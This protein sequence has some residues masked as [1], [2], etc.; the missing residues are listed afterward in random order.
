MHE[1]FLSRLHSGPRVYVPCLPPA[2][3]ADQG[4]NLRFATRTTVLACYEPYFVRAF[5]SIVVFD[6]TDSTCGSIGTIAK[7][8]ARL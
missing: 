2:D 5:G 1:S 8:G 3:R 7:A 4:R 6:V